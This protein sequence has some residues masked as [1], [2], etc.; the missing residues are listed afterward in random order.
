LGVSAK[1]AVCFGILPETNQVVLSRERSFMRKG[2]VCRS[3]TGFP[4]EPPAQPLEIT[5]RLRHSKTETP[6]P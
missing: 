3:K 5:V 2:Y 1:P 6:R 4:I